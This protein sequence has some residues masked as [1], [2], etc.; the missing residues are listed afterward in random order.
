LQSDVVNPADAAEQLN[1]IRTL[2]ERAALYRRALGPTLVGLGVLGLAAGAL[3]YG[4]E[5]GQDD[6]LTFV[7]YWSTVALLGVVGTLLQ[8]RRQALGAAEQ[9]FTPPT[10]RIVGAMLPIYGVAIVGTIYLTLL[11]GA[12]TKVIAV[13]V[14]PFWMALHGLALHAAGHFTFR[15]IRWLGWAFIGAGL[16]A[17]GLEG[18][19]TL[20]R[21]DL[22]TM[23]QAHLLMGTV[24]GLGHLL[25][26]SWI[27]MAERRALP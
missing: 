14:L 18:Y 4:M 2:M 9:F 8:M 10:R 20:T 1:T 11:F 22:P 21:A 15:G 26:G 5:I 24:F 13:T 3:G 7:L 12:M 27:L 25:A 23:A 19:W 17:G 6:S 16:A